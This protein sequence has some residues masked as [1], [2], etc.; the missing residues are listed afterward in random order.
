MTGLTEGHSPGRGKFW[1]VCG[2]PQLLSAEILGAYLLGSNLDS[3]VFW[4]HNFGQVTSTPHILISLFENEFKS[5]KV[6]MK[7]LGG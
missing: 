6:V 5:H 7:D 3:T 2:G 4:L 1:G